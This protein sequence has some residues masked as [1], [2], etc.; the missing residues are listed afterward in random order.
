MPSCFSRYSPSG[1]NLRMSSVGA[2]SGMALTFNVSAACVSRAEKDRVRPTANA[3]VRLSMEVLRFN[4]GK[5][6][7]RLA[8]AVCCTTLREGRR[9]RRDYRDS[10]VL[11]QHCNESDGAKTVGASLLAIAECQSEV[12]STDP[13]PSRASSLPQ[14]LRCPMTQLIGISLLQLFWKGDLHLC[15]RLCQIST[16]VFHVLDANRQSHQPVTDAQL[17]AGGGWNGGVGH[18]RRVFDQAFHAAQ[19]LGQGEDLHVLKEAFGT[20]QVA[21][22]VDGNHPAETAHL[23]LGQFVLRVRWQ[24]GVVDP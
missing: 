22:E 1:L 8:Q 12:V 5:M 3:R 17:C 21:V 20:S 23:P 16:Q 9:K 6:S 15:Q 24:A 11:D 7:M 2:S 18:D 4:S 10:C 14:E 19:A 13:P